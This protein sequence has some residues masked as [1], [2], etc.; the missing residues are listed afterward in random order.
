MSKT[1]NK[2]AWERLIKKVES[3]FSPKGKLLIGGLLA[4]L[5]GTLAYGT[6]MG[7]VSRT[8]STVMITNSAETSGGSGVILS[9]ATTESKILT[10][11]HICRVVKD[12]GV[13][14]TSLQ[15]K[16][17][18]DSYIVSPD[19]DVCMIT[20]K[21][22][23]GVNT[24]L[25]SRAPEIMDSASISGH[26]ALL[27]N[28]ISKGHFAQRKVIYLLH[29]IREC[30]KEDR[31]DAKLGLFCMFFGK[32]P[33]FKAYESRVVTATIMGGSSGSAVYNW[34]NQI[35]GLAFAGNGKGLSFAFA[36]PYEYVASFVTKVK[37]SPETLYR[38]SF[39]PEYKIDIKDLM[40]SASPEDTFTTNFRII[41]KKC[42][43]VGDEHEP[44]IKQACSYLENNTLWLKD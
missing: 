7:T 6:F 19:H 32:L 34:R 40:S 21:T 30:T 1:N 15:E 23:L 8:A 29:S 18:V 28:V 13:V 24:D 10:N 43:K 20:V 41:V 36:V 9:S 37:S 35:S 11:A 26:P 2:S 5:I 39:K 25:A 42:S 27:P 3:K 4:T 16:Y 12:G 38:Q 17:L 22:D 31:Q 14:K 33:V 44:E